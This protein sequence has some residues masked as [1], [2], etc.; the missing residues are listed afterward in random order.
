M[1]LDISKKLGALL[2]P[3]GCRRALGLLAMTVVMGLL[4]MASV[5]SIMPFMAVLANPDVVDSNPYISAAYSWFGFSSRH[6]FILCLAFVVLAFALGVTAFKALAT[7]AT[8][9]F[10]KSQSYALSYRL[11]QAYFHHPYEWFLGKHGAELGRSVL[12]EVGQVVSGCLAP[13][14]QLVMQVVVAACLMVLLFVVDPALSLVVALVFGG[15]YGLLLWI[16]RRY[17]DRLGSDRLDA[18]RE[19]FR[20]SSEALSAIKEI[21]ILGLERKFL[22]RFAKPSQ[23]LVR[24]A[25]NHQLIA[26]LPQHAMQTI[27]LVTIMFIVIYLIGVHDGLSQALPVIAVYAMA[28]RRLQ[29]A[30]QRAYLSLTTLRFNKPALDH[31]YHD[32]IEENADGP[33]SA[34]RV[35]L[36]EL[37]HEIKLRN[38]SYRYPHGESAA[39]KVQSL[40]IPARTTVGFVGQTGAGKTTAVDLILGLLSP[41]EGELLVDG[42]VIGPDNR[43]AWQNCLGYVPQHIVFAD[44]TIAANIAFGVSPDRIDMNVVERVARIA[45]LH[46]FVT[47]ELRD[48]YQTK[49]GERGVRLSGGQQQRIGIARALYRDPDVII[50]DEATS[51]LDN[52]TERAVIDAVHNLSHK[53]TIILIAH[54]LTTVQ[55]CDIIF[56]F[57]KGRVVASGTHDQL[58]ANNDRFRSMLESVMDQPTRDKSEINLSVQTVL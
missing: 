1:I 47:E 39:L 21:K 14:I 27:S 30:L 7:W 36:D 2:E 52:I 29:P 16:S 4:E 40:T 19:R 48:G 53:K 6:S 43:S 58:A 18:N 41:T 23:R 34:S 13:S 56:V 25:A 50:M 55:R 37:R 5:G 32:L 38:I 9:R 44:D 31:L 12:A 49:I 45:N 24:H 15:A 10:T 46:Q 22:R 11:L 33:V 28:G 8:V 54:R 26:Q 57:D 35:R 20:V 42:V 3:S 51:A 17:V